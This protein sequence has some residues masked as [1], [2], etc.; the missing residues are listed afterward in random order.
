[1]RTPL[2][3]TTS[4]SSSPSRSL[5]LPLAAAATT[6]D[7][8]AGSA[9]TGPSSDAP[10]PSSE[11]GAAGRFRNGPTAVKSGARLS[12]QECR[13]AQQRS[14]AAHEQK[15]VNSGQEWLGGCGFLARLQQS[16]SLNKTWSK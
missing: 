2:S 8:A 15:A 7:A 14:K 10:P 12:G 11:A 5:S 13:T 16:K 6:T 3:P 4:T 1:M 9:A